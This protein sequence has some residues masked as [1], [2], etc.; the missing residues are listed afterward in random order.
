M[1]AGAST[2]ALGD[3][4]L[5]IRLFLTVFKTGAREVLGRRLEVLQR[6]A[7][8]RRGESAPYMSAST[9]RRS[10]NSSQPA[11]IV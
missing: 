4:S 3:K 7:R 10:T 5:Q 1:L 8:D 11:I 9:L 2:G 6:R